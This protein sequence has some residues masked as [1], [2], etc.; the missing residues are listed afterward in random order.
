MTSSPT[1]RAFAVNES[2]GWPPSV[3]PLPTTFAAMSG[4]STVPPSVAVAESAPSRR[5]ASGSI[6][7]SSRADGASMEISPPIARVVRLARYSPLMRAVPIV[8]SMF[9]TLTAR[10]DASKSAVNAAVPSDGTSRP[11]LRAE[12]AKRGAL[13]SPLSVMFAS[14][15]PSLLRMMAGMEKPNSAAVRATSPTSATRASRRPPK[16][17]RVTAWRFQRPPISPLTLVVPSRCFCSARQRLPST[18]NSTLPAR[19]AVPRAARGVDV[20]RSSSLNGS[21]GLASSRA[22]PSSAAPNGSGFTSARRK[23]AAASMSR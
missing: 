5:A 12:P 6:V 8:P 20:L 10:A 11:A 16:V 21:P 22:V 18:K 9:V 19:G 2:T 17:E 1:I 15:G 7:S 23:T 3:M 4:A 14:R 13:N